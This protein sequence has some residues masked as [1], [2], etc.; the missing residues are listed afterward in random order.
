[1]KCMYLFFIFFI[2][3]NL[4]NSTLLFS[5]P[6]SVTLTNENILVVEKNGIYI[7]DPTM[8]AIINTTFTFIEEE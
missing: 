2:K 6:T 4:I 8:E 5:Y 1:M 3:L 7:C